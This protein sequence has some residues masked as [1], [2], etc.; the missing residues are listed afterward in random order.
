MIFD[1]WQ[2]FTL[3]LFINS[4]RRI[5]EVEKPR[6]RAL[7]TATVTRVIS[8]YE[9]TK[10]ALSR[11]PSQ[12]SI[13]PWT[14]GNQHL[15]KIMEG[16]QKVVC[17]VFCSFAITVNY[18]LR[19][20]R[21]N[22]CQIQLQTVS[23]NNVFSNKSSWFVFSQPFNLSISKFGNKQ[24]KVCLIRYKCTRTTLFAGFYCFSFTSAEKQTLTTTSFKLDVSCQ[25]FFAKCLCQMSQK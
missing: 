25:M 14:F 21:T 5:N 6:G 20:A 17:C 23:M 7:H 10:S 13:G 18:F 12:M 9:L 24:R 16:T 3:Q 1:I 22:S 11:C 15:A 4:D 8:N 2:N 19:V